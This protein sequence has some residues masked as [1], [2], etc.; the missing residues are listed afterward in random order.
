MKKIVNLLILFL[1]VII[2]FVGVNAEDSTTNGTITINNATE[3]EFYNIYRI[4]ELTYSGNNVAYSI[5]KD[6][7]AFF[8]DENNASFLSTTAAEGLNQISV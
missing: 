7:I 4:F 8:N 5:D 6:W 3:G 2:P 1:A